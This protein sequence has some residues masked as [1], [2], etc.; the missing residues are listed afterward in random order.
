MHSVFDTMNAYGRRGIP[1]FFMADFEL[2]KPVVQRLDHAADNSILYKFGAS[3]NAGNAANISVRKPVLLRKRPVPFA[4]YRQAFDYVVAQE[5]AGNSYLVNLTFPVEI[6]ISGT[7]SDIFALSNARYKLLYNN[8]FVVFSPETFVKIEKGIIRTF[9][10]KGTIPAGIPGAAKRILNDRKEHAEHVTIVDLLRNDLSTV[11]EDVRV[12]RFRYLEKIAAN[13]RDLLQVSSEITGRLP[14]N[15]AENIG[16]ILYA[17][18]PA[19]SVSGAPKNKTLEII[20]HAEGG[21]RGYYCGIMGVFDGTNLDSA[22]MIRFIERRGGALVYR[23]GG[24]VTVNS[25][26]R[27]EYREMADKVYL[28]F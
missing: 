10:M 7:L 8:E 5:K 28:P 6:D 23:S 3:G 19:G 9:P 24:G 13:G 2:S 12:A 14:D 1:F 22:V 18:L 26:A 16:N 27:A 25:T 4:L 20:R 21:P 17:M 11:A 15:Y